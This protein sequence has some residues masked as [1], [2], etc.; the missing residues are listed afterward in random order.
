MGED[1]DIQ[2]AMDDLLDVQEA[3]RDLEESLY[4]VRNFIDDVRAATDRMVE[5]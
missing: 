5:D 4:S 3:M 1:A 2:S